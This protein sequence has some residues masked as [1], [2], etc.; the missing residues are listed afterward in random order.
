MKN[1]NW[2]KYLLH[3]AILIG[4]VVAGI[5]YLNGEEVLGALRR[6]NYTFAPFILALSAVYLGLKA[7]R[8][9]FLMAPVS[10]LPWGV[11]FRGYT[12]GQAATLIPGGVAARAG[13]M[14]QAG[15]PISK[16]SAPVAY[17]SILD[18]VVF[19][20]SSL[21][22]AL[23]FPGARTA[24]FI[25]LG[26]LAV[27]ALLFFVPLTRNWMAGAAN[28]LAGRF[29][30]KEKWH[31]FLGAMRE[32]GTLKILGITLGITVVAFSL[33]IIALDLVLRGLDFQLSYP[34]LFLAYILP[35]MLG[36]MSALPAGVGVTEAGMVGFLSSTS[37][38]DADTAAAAVAI[39]RIGTVVFQALLGAIVYYL[40]WKGDKEGHEVS[41]P[42]G[43]TTEPQAEAA[44]G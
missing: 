5:K 34:K 2:L 39:F 10:A 26:V 6:F 42:E 21:V 25:L 31:N 9:V 17:S 35:T 18:Q 4:L 27:L 12:A 24:A 40:F 20:V 1:F 37:S 33:K 43:D 8:F 29:N 19:I 44:G 13:L 41:A 15:V 16:S 14:K 22:A 28:W 36:R 38:I 30:F 11:T 3:A 7:W 32:V 23:F